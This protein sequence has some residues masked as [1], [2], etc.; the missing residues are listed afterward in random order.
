MADTKHLLEFLEGGV[1][2]F[3]D[4]GVE[5]VRVEFA[6]VSPTCFWGQRSLAGGG[7]ITVD[8]APTEV[9]T[10]RGFDF[11]STFVDEFHHSFTQIKAIG[12]HAF[13]LSDYVPMSI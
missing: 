2:M 8:S 3:F 5:L 1:G 9:K 11:G 4:M 6:P 10:P 13:N 12:F 7:Q